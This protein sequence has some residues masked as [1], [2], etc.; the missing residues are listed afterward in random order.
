MYVYAS[1]AQRSCADSVRAESHVG[2]KIE[3]RQ[4][5]ARR[6]RFI[7]VQYWGAGERVVMKG[8]EDQRENWWWADHHS[9]LKTFSSGTKSRSHSRLSQRIARLS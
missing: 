5:T 7:W 6:R 2:D 1:Y 8:T 4:E 3:S 9:M